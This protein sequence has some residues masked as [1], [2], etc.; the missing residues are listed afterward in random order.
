[1][2]SLG[3]CL[4]ELYT[5]KI[6]FAGRNNNEMLRVF[7]ELRGKFPKKLL[8]RGAFR[9][10]HFDDNFN[11]LQQDIDTVSQKPIV[12]VISDI[13]T[14]D[15]LGELI[16]PGAP[17]LTDKEHKKVVELK[18]LLERCLTLD[19]AKRIQPKDALNHPFLL[20]PR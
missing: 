20:P 11:Y 10:K 9:G 15:L 5:G 2:W 19:P 8:R 13:R 18:D 14:R 12:R 1:M 7:M 4:A 3:C 17:K 6:L 16:P